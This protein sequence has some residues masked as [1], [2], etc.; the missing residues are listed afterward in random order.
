MRPL[1]VVLIALAASLLVSLAVV[2]IQSS[3]NRRDQHPVAARTTDSAAASAAGGG[4]LPDLGEFMVRAQIH[5]QKLYSAGNAANWKLA[6]FELDELREAL[7]EAGK[8]HDRWKDLPFRL[9]SMIPSMMTGALQGCEESIRTADKAT[10][11][12]SFDAIASSCNSCHLTAGRS[13]IV[14][15]TPSASAFPNQQFTPGE[16]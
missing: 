12:R 3:T 16:K 10:F 1:Q 7:T 11:V 8:Y 14:I 4:Y 13:F 9:S 2:A 5:H 15:Q 6:Q